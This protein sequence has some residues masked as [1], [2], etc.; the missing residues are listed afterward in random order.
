MK[1]SKVARKII[2]CFALVLFLPLAFLTVDFLFTRTENSMYE[3]DIQIAKGIIAGEIKYKGPL[4]EEHFRIKDEGKRGVYYYLTEEYRTPNSDVFEFK[5]K[6]VFLK[7]ATTMR[8]GR[9]DNREALRILTRAR[10]HSDNV[11]YIRGAY[12]FMIIS[13]VAF[14]IF[15]YNLSQPNKAKGTARS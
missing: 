6:R 8:V 13:A 10:E 4:D 1:L 14:G 3:E 5:D 9:V 12:I 7:Q 11:R 15:L 2:T